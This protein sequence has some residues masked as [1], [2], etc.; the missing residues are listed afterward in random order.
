[1][2]VCVCACLC[3]YVLPL[4]CAYVCMRVCVS[5]CV[6]LFVCAYVCARAHVYVCLLYLRM[7]TCACASVSVASRT[8][9]ARCEPNTSRTKDYF[10][11]CVEQIFRDTFRFL[12]NISSARSCPKPTFFD[13][14]AKHA[15]IGICA[16][17]SAIS[18]PMP[19][20]LLNSGFPWVLPRR[21]LAP[22]AMVWYG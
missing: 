8:Q 10:E 20:S 13:I 17:Y 4:L 16:N 12:R 3:M 18:R 21:E 11:K 7:C 1:M 6:C 19:D 14:L 15:A 2:Y 9:T 22:D 5:L